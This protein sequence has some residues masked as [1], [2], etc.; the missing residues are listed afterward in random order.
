MDDFRDFL[1]TFAGT[2]PD[3]VRTLCLQEFTAG[4]SDQLERWSA[5]GLPASAVPRG[6]REDYRKRLDY[7]AM[8]DAA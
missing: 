2:L 5:R 1:N 7:V 3:A 8:R 6:I 4:R